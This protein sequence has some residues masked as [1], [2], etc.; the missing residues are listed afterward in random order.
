M[1][2]RTALVLSGGGMFGAWQAGAWKALASRFQPDLVVGASVGSLN[3]YAI[4]GGASG[5]ALC[6]FRW[7]AGHNPPLSPEVELVMIKPAKPLGSVNDALYWKRDNIDKW[8]NLG[9][10]AATNI[11]LPNCI[12]R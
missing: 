5:Q 11:S 7:A 12:E 1:K 8:L 4:A 10:E 2:T 3:G 6:D 9:F